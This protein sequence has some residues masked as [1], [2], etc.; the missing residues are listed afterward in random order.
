MQ[1]H[2]QFSFL[3]FSFWLLAAAQ[4]YAQVPGYK[5][6]ELEDNTAKITAIFRDHQGYILVGSTNGLYKFDGIRFVKIETNRPGI[7]DTVTAIFQDNLQHTWVGFQSG[8]I[9]KKTAG[10]LQYIEPEE[11]SP[12]KRITAFLQD[13]E[14]NTWIGTR[15]EGIY[16]FKNKRL[17]LINEQEGLDDLNIH[18]L[19]I[20]ASGDILAASDQGLAVCSVKGST[21]K[22]TV[23]GPAQGLPDY[24]I[25]S[26]AAAGNNQFW[27]GL[28]DKGICLYDHLS[29]KIT[30]PPAFANWNKGQV[31]ALKYAHGNVWITTQDSG[32]LCYSSLQQRLVSLPVLTSLQKNTGGVIEDA[33]G[34]M[35]L[36]ADNKTLVRITGNALQLHPLYTEEFFATVHTILVDKDNAFWTGTDMAVVKYTANG[37]GYSSKRYPVP[38]L[39]VKTDITSLY[40]DVLGNIWIGTMG[41]GIY[42]LD[43]LSGRSRQLKEAFSSGSN[44]ILSI[45]GNGPT[46]CTAGLEGALVFELAAGNNNINHSYSFTSYNN[47]HTIGSTY[48]YH[49]FKDSKKRIWFATDGKGL[50]MLNNGQFTHYGKSSGIRDEHIYAV[51]EDARGIIW[52]STSNA[53]IYAF[54]GENFTNYALKE[55]LSSLSVSAVKAGGKGNIVVVHKT[56]IDIIDS[57]TGKFSYINAEQGLAA[58]NDDLGAVCTDQ[59]GN[60]LVATPKGIVQYTAL[61]QVRTAPVTV[62]ESVQLFLAAIDT[63]TR[64]SFKHDENNIT[65]NFAGVYL[66]D[67]ENV[68]YQYKLQGLYN[69]WQFT[70][71][72]NQSFPK[73]PPGKYVFRVRS[74]LNKN[75]TGAAEASFAFEITQPFWKTWW[76]IVG[77][78]LLF[79]GLLY[80]YIKRREANVTYVERLQG[81]K[82]KFE[83]EVL[84]NQVNP[85][86]LFNSFNTLI[87]TIEENP[88]AAVEYVEQLSDFFRNIVNYRDKDTISLKEEI[89]LLQNYL[90]LQQKRY[91]NY[92]QLQISIAAHDQA[93]IF[94]PPLTLQL[95]VENAIKHNVVS[96]EAAL[97]VQLS[98]QQEYVVIQNNINVKINR[99]KGTGMG[100]QNIVNRYALLCNTPVLIKNT[101]EHFIVSLPVLKHN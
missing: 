62:I 74:S 18:D 40:Q 9:A 84:R 24:I 87:S 60:V 41:S 51:T 91:G 58:I 69:E 52:F 27:I 61:D 70:N 19:A 55:G 73:L 72:N 44:S 14:H 11:G 56:G 53:G 6:F 10:K 80:W 15:G 39:D 96:K 88:G 79:A 99:E 67:P 71:N 32:L 16:Y 45:T 7:T 64:H 5:K 66:T 75:F 86:F 21:K 94:L 46:V 76:F 43:P 50:T 23:I 98:L 1:R 57:K 36:V 100:L 82:M 83:F 29:K 34:N 77:C 38:G 93:S 49:V 59:Y 37:N 13:K 95:L 22:V 48:I 2:Q 81:E 25:T 12:R 26:I 78:T 3:L 65:F 30:V 97:L 101:G 47:V 4:T 68:Y 85:H 35:W 8:H 33:E 42:V 17:Y 54:D 31:N 92:L 89:G 63:V 28:Q 20:T 90:Y